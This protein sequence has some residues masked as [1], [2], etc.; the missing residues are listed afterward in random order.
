MER[1]LGIAEVAALYQISA[2]TLRYYE[3]VGIL[4]SHRKTD[5]KY[6]EYDREQCER[7]EIILL[8]RR[9]SFS[10]KIITELLR[11]DDAHFRTVLHEKIAES[12]KQL[13]EVR[14]TDRLLRDLATELSHKP[15]TALNAVDI[16]SR[17]TYL[18]N[19]TE[20]VIPMNAP[21]SEKYRVAFGV[22]II[23]AL[24]AENPNFLV[25]K[26][27]VLRSELEKK[28]AVLPKIRLYDNADLPQNQVVIFWDGKEVWRKEFASID[29]AICDEI[30][31]QL[32]LN[33]L[34][35]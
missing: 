19:K 5:S 31:M 32:R 24:F 21:Q 18:T 14:E 12:G 4:E 34:K 8:L 6:R 27:G 33:C 26:I 9:L 2:R 15:I 25:E 11:G 20:R 35:K 28:F 23:R 3:E 13:L 29:A 16:L 17:Y 7:L 30:I 10:L 1:R 22:Q